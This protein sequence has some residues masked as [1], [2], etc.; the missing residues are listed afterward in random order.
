VAKY[1]LDTTILIEHLR[2]R[3]E[4][5]ELLTVLARQGHRLGLCC[6]NVAELYSGLSHE[7]RAWADRL[8]DSLDFYDVTREVAKQA[9]Q[10]RY[11]FARRGVTL[12]TADTLVAATAS[13]E[14]ATLVTANT[15]DF[16]MKEID[17]LEHP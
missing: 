15:E 8:I 13:T 14:G 2:G 5:V 1:L 11:D 7:E 4:A 3:K 17:L 10:Y 6:I 12:S 16:P 9:G